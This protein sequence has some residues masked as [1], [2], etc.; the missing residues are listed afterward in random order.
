MNNACKLASALVF[1]SSGTSLVAQTLDWGTPFGTDIVDSNGTPIDSLYVIEIGA[2]EDGF[3][4]DE[5]NVSSWLTNWRVFDSATYNSGLMFFTGQASMNDDGTSTSPTSTST[6]D[7]QGLNAFLW[8]RKGDQPV[9]GSEW[10]LTRSVSS[11][12]EK[13][14]VFPNAVPGCCDHD[15]NFQWSVSNLDGDDIPQWGNQ[16][17]VYG[18]GV[19]STTGPYTL[20]TY[21]FVPEPGVPLM[22]LAS[23]AVLFSRRRRPLA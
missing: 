17:G 1:L 11:D 21:T 12:P 2:F 20:Q 9:E 13:N 7:F 16:G 8:I 19:F 15:T 6:F 10:L 3:T 18:P 14:W 22:V 4:P 23:S 5:T